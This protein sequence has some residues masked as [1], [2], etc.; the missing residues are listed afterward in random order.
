[1]KE[2]LVNKFSLY[3][4]LCDPSIFTQET[5]QRIM[6]LER[7]LKISGMQLPKDPTQSEKNFH[8]MLHTQ[9]ELVV[10]IVDEANT[11]AKLVQIKTTIAPHMKILQKE[12]AYKERSKSFYIRWLSSPCSRDSHPN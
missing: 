5:S 2:V 1:M 8:T 11:K 4:K 10:L 9:K 7:N 3:T 12:L 6:S